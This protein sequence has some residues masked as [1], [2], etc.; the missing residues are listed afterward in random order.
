MCVP[1]DEVNT[2]EGA[3]HVCELGAE[4]DGRQ[5]VLGLLDADLAAHRLQVHHRLQCQAVDAWT[6]DL[7]IQSTSNLWKHSH[8]GRCLTFISSTLSNDI[9]SVGVQPAE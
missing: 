7:A 6:A 1:R 9:S 3:G 8:L 2:G 5:E 4:I